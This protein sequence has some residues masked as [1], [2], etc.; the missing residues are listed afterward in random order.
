MT[1]LSLKKNYLTNSWENKSVHAFSMDISSKV[2]VI[3]RLDFGHVD[4]EAQFN[5]LA[6]TSQGRIPG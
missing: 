1:T 2:N 5:A 6:I 3:A 4:V